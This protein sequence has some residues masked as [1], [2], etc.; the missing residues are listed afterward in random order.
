[1][2]EGLQIWLDPE[3]YGSLRPLWQDSYIWS[4]VAVDESLPLHQTSFLD[5]D[6]KEAQE[7]QE[8]QEASRRKSDSAV[9]DPQQQQLQ[10]QLQLQ[11]QRNLKR[12]SM[13]AGHR[14]D[15]SWEE[16]E[17]ARTLSPGED[18]EE[19]QKGKG[20]RSSS[21]DRPKRYTGVKADRK[22]SPKDDRSTTRRPMSYPPPPPKPG[23]GKRM[24]SFHLM[25]DPIEQE[26]SLNRR[27]SSRRTPRTIPEPEEAVD[28][29][30]DDD[31]S[32]EE[33]EVPAA[34][35][36]RRRRTRKTLSNI[37][38]G[39]AMTSTTPDKEDYFDQEP[40]AKPKG[41]SRTATATEVGSGVG[42]R[43]NTQAAAAQG[44]LLI[45]TTIHV[46]ILLLL[47]FPTTPSPRE[48]EQRQHHHQHQIQQQTGPDH[49][50]RRP[51]PQTLHLHLRPA[52]RHVLQ[53]P[54]PD[55]EEQLEEGEEPSRPTTAAAAHG[56][57][58]A[59]ASDEFAALRG[60]GAGHAHG[61]GDVVFPHK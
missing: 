57:N 54:S 47:L 21:Q 39:Q 22:P 5:I 7:A 61:R 49:K 31:Y 30:D 17:D 3:K 28:S 42:R 15:A 12:K 24:K 58:S 1:M 40:P 53:R 41:R 35:I 18:Y 44:I 34:R 51:S 43:T 16:D 55:S 14:R 38:E 45:L 56:H 8:A 11:H 23:M 13:M 59:H 25:K 46:R 50:S 26:K 48:E 9:L 52:R 36:P 37:Q 19:E 2:S 27:S 20:S 10:L 4:P 60:H 29:D 6:E 33:E 32:E